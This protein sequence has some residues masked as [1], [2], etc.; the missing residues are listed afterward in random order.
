M[1]IHCGEVIGGT[2]FLTHGRL[3]AFVQ[4][5]EGRESTLY[6]IRPGQT[7]IL[8]V[9]C[10]FSGVVYPAWVAAGEET[11]RGFF[12]PSATYRTLFDEEPEVRNFTIGV[13]TSW[14]YDM[15]TRVEETSLSSMA[16]RIA[17]AL[18]RRANTEGIIRGTHQDI[19][20]DLGTAREVVSRHLKEFETQGFIERGRRQI[21]LIDSRRLLSAK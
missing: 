20:L 7:C 16:Q 17:H 21:R 5:A 11:T 19:A 10:T 14:I 8:A 2:Y 12:L 1:V 4:N 13:L 18:V 9:N 15:M 3:R 6:S